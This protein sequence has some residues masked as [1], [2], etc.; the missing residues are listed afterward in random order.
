MA[1]Y[2]LVLA[3][4]PFRRLLLAH[5]L[6][7]LGQ[8]QLTMAVGVD[9]QARTGSGI[10]LSIAVAL[11]V[12]PYIVCSYAAGVLADRHSRS[13]VL[14]GSIA[15]RVIT[16]GI[17]A[18]AVLAA[19][20]VPVVIA[21]AALTAVAATPAYPALAA[22]TPQVIPGRQLGAANS[23]VTGVEN[24]AW[25][26]GPGVL[27]LVLLTGAPVWGGCLAAVACLAAGLVAIRGVR[28][29]TPARTALTEPS[30]GPTP[31][32]GGGL[33]EELGAG[34]RAVV[35]VPRVLAAFVVAMVDNFLFGYL[36]VAL[37]LVGTDG[38]ELA[39]DGIGALTTAFALGALA[40][41]AINQRLA[42]PGREVPVLLVGMAAFAA[43][44]A[45]LALADSLP[46][47]VVLLALAGLLTLVVE[48][49]AVTVIQRSAA[50]EVAARVFGLYDTVAIALIAL[51]SGLAGVLSD[52]L[53][54]ADGLLVVTAVA[55]LAT[56][57]SG[58]AM[59]RSRELAL[60][61]GLDGT[62]LDGGIATQDVGP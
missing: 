31:A 54:L 36:V 16:G 50:E 11:G 29:P 49:V 59:A 8:L 12:A 6:A 25:V 53:G 23:L 55:A 51:G 15:V 61:D 52:T 24:A 56:T 44:T 30:Q 2:R 4:R 10:W 20:P 18:L 40:S 27:G 45:G 5:A 35:G 32:P 62:D 57:V 26:A 48:V 22:A 13:Q 19:A 58:V 1:T 39:P 60:A 37:V 17:T 14:R 28:T 3:V 34:V 33:R 46:A 21:L 7:T 9:A 43:V 42:D 41:F 38:L 47:A